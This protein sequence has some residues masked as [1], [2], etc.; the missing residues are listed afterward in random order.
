MVNAFNSSDDDHGYEVGHGRNQ[1]TGEVQSLPDI[2]REYHAAGLRWV[3]IGDSNTGEGSSREHAAM[4]PRFRGCVLALARSFARIHETNL[5][6]Q[7]VLALTFAD[8][9]RLRAHRRGR[10][11]GGAGIGGPRAGAAGDGGGHRTRRLSLGLRGMPH[12][13]RW[14]DRLVPGRKRAEH[15]LASRAG[16]NL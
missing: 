14:A 11:R 13:Q 7:G 10:P 15:H 2:A 9:C 1:L 3:F 8:P 5:K 16:S 6:K 12:P 4:E